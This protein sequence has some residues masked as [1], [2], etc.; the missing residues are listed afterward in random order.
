[1]TEKA[2]DRLERIVRHLLRGRRLRLG[3]AD[4]AEQATIMAAAR[5]AAAREGYP[6]LRPAFRRR[7]AAQ[8]AEPV[9]SRWISRRAA[10]VAGLGVAAGTLS[11]IGLGRMTGAPSAQKA[12][13]APAPT[14][15]GTPA[16]GTSAA[17]FIDPRR[18]VWTA[19]AH[20]A[21][22]PEGQAVKVRAGSVGAYLFRSGDQVT[23]V[24]SICS[25]L[26]CELDWRSGSEELVCPCHNVAFTS[27]GQPAYDGYSVEPLSQVRVRVVDG[28]VEVLGT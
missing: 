27:S 15:G 3:P 21:D 5:L 26:P 14:S 8:L 12:A 28:Q 2:A 1:M 24:S 22:L 18:P 23:A 17:G 20:L 25:H 11:G 19:V 13:H 7:L 9:H 4:S 16:A 6:R 10:L